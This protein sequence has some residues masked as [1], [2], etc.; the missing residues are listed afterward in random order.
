MSTVAD[1]SLRT[2]RPW[3]WPLAVAVLLTMGSACLLAGWLPIGFSIVTVF[4]FA[5]PHNW[6]EARYFLSRMP[7][8][9]G[10]LRTFF[11]TGIAGVVA[12]TAGF[13]LLPW[14]AERGSW[15]DEGWRVAAA[16]WNSLLVVWIVALVQIRSRQNPTFDA[17]W[18]IPIGSIMIAAAWLWPMEWGLLLVY[19]H[20]IV[21]LW[22]L[23]RELGRQ[24]PAWQGTYRACLA[25]LPLFLAALW[26]RLAS[27]P[28]LPGVDALTL[29]ITSHAG[30]D[31][32]GGVS[33]HLLVATHTFLESL[34]YAIWIVAIPLVSFRAAPWQLKNVPLARRSM[35]WRRALAGVVAAG[36]LVML[37]L[38]ACFLANYPLTRDVYFTVAMLHVL[39]EIPF[40]LRLS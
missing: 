7:G 2:A 22:F 20:P 34:H 15:G 19:L 31:V 8:R 38:W 28:S 12:L 24:R 6:L 14:L 11:L 37:L 25:C 9:W 39:A 32:L 30:A 1:I 29:R 36:A 17:T 33:S 23:D 16:A 35:T 3:H 21:A 18:S 13:A 26:W 40:L 27:A 5:G 10:A 4:L